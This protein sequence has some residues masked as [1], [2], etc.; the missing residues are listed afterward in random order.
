MNI[1]KS[2]QDNIEAYLYD[3][4]NITMYDGLI[5]IS[6]YNEITALEFFNE[7]FRE[8]N[9]FIEN[10]ENYRTI[11]THFEEY[12][13]NY[14]LIPDDDLELDEYYSKIRFLQCLAFLIEYHFNENDD[15]ITLKSCEF[16]KGLTHK[17]FK[18]ETIEKKFDFDSAVEFI[19][20]LPTTRAKILFLTYIKTGYL[21]DITTG[22]IKDPL[23]EILAINFKNKCELEIQK[24]TEILQI[25]TES[26]SI[27]PQTITQEQTKELNGLNW[28]G[29]ELQF[30][31]LTKALFET[32]LISPEI[33]Q[34]EFFKRMKQFFNVKDFDDKEKLKGIRA[35]TKDLTPFI[36]TIET[37]LN[38]WIKNKD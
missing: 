29:S 31:E 28:Q 1:I 38:N 36:N 11:K 14:N 4:A 35:R 32:K 15:E 25:E 3:D 5:D 22:Y 20:T 8:F 17:K 6:K 19:K 10:K 21:Q 33:T 18:S 23:S 26:L 16:I 34:K 12:R 27:L 37:S 9:F 30:T 2:P 24:Y 13:I 7:L